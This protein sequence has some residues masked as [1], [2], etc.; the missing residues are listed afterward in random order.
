MN[1]EIIRIGLKP[2]L[3]LA[4]SLSC[5]AQVQEIWLTL[6]NSSHQSD[7]WANDIAMD[8]IGNFY[9]T[10]FCNTHS[11]TNVDYCTVKYSPAGEQLWAAEYDGPGH[12]DDV[13]KVV[14]VDCWGNVYITGYSKGNSLDYATIKYNSEG[15]QQWVSRYNGSA[16]RTDIVNAM[17]LDSSGNVFITGSSQGVHTN[18]DIVTLKYDS[19]GQVQWLTRYNGP[20]GGEDA[21]MSIALD[22]RGNLCITG[23]SEGVGTEADIITFK[24]TNSG[25]LSWEA[26]YNSPYNLTDHGDFICVNRDDFISVI[27]SS[28]NS[29]GNFDYLT[30]RYNTLGIQQWVTRYDGPGH[31]DDCAVGAVPG[32]AGCLYVLGC[33]VNVSTAMDYCTIKYNSRGVQQWVAF[34]NG[35]GN[36]NDGPQEIVLDSLE[37]LYITGTSDGFNPPNADLCTLKYDSSGNQIWVARHNGSINRADGAQALVLTSD[38]HVVVTGVSM[39]MGTGSDFCTIEYLQSCGM[40]IPVYSAIPPS[41]FSL[42]YPR[43]NPFNPVTVISFQLPHAGHLNLSVFDVTGRMV[44]TLADASLSAGT[45]EVTFHGSN[46]ASGLYFVRMKADG[47]NQTMKVLLV[48]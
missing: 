8:S 23:Y 29:S 17:V 3:L 15:V 27:G 41:G 35:S 5:Q 9:V 19:T 43:P 34:Y 6:F 2:A 45:H 20:A 26:R 13:A 14:A 44:A 11:L 31:S 25:Q 42:F 47:F 30:I 7:D 33:V 21:G 28:V 46:L 37:N 36:L 24:Y 1:A 10:G 32:A 40:A 18:S 48:K 12:G 22:Y 16:D 38:C 4:V 39:E